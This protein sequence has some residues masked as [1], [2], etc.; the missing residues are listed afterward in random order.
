VRIDSRLTV[1]AVKSL[2]FRTVVGVGF[3]Y[4]VVLSQNRPIAEEAPANLRPFIVGPVQRHLFHVLCDLKR[5][6]V[7]AGL[8]RLLRLVPPWVRD[9]SALLICT[10]PFLSMLHTRKSFVESRGEKMLANHVDESC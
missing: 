7:V 4:E 2:P 9:A 1:F 5:N 8:Y 3:R 10:L 6:P